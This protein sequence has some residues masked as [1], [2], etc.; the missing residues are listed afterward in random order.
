MIK[1]TTN[2]IRTHD[3]TVSVHL[4]SPVYLYC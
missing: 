4:T 3:A 1:K 2:F